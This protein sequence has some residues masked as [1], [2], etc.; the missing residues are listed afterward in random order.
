[1]NERTLM[2]W[3]VVLAIF[4]MGLTLSCLAFPEMRQLLPEWVFAK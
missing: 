3:T 4:V 1:M 2:R